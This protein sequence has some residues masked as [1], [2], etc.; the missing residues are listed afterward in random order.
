MFA[1]LT[2][3]EL[4]SAVITLSGALPHWVGLPSV[5]MYTKW[6]V[7]WALGAL[8]EMAHFY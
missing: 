4:L 8:P 7:L 6:G 3:D 2:E 5:G 1:K